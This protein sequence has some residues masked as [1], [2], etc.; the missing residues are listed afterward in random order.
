MTAADRYGPYGWHDDRPEYGKIKVAWDTI[1]WSSLQN[2]CLQR[3]ALRFQHPTPIRPGERRFRMREADEDIKVPIP[4][5]LGAQ[6]NP[7]TAI[8]FRAREGYNYTTE[9]LV[10]LR[11]TITETSLRFGSDYTVFLLVDVKDTSRNIFSTEADY[12][13]AIFDLVPPEFQGITVLFDETLLASWYPTIK[14]HSATYQIMQ[15]LQLFGHFY[16]EF[17]H[18][19]QLELDV[20]FTGHAGR[21]LTAL[22]AFARAQPRKQAAERSTW[23][24]MP[25]VHGP[26][27]ALLAAVNATL[28]GGGG[29]AW[30]SL[31]LPT[32][33]SGFLPLGPSGPPDPLDDDFA[34][35]VGDEADFIAFAPCAHI[36]FLRDW[37]WR[38][39]HQGF[40]RRRAPPGGWMCQPAMG[41]ASRVLLQAVHHAQARLG[42]A[43]HS[44]ATLS[45][46][47][48]W[49]GLKLVA[50]P[51]PLFQDPRWDER[52][53]DEVYNGAARQRP[54]GMRG[55]AYGEAVYRGSPWEYVTQKASFWWRSGFPDRIYDAWLGRKGRSR[56]CHEP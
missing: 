18:V 21:Y 29:V 24:Y 54:E 10:N 5:P 27:S 14:S 53:M 47:A 25:S 44:E 35:G 17:A 34:W 40:G 46:F 39:W 37:Y 49:H 28:S 30:P 12:Q 55:M 4:E 8:V 50:P 6:Y 22:A 38:D 9:D 26:Y 15:P 1:D 48:L 7:R 42:L 56:R 3:N 51:G 11:A 31:A 20:R 2:H 36:P 43:I 52:D 45:S 13:R 19:W 16:P 23:F 33:A 41:R 32:P